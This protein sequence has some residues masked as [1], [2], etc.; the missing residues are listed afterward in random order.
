MYYS[1]TASTDLT[2]KGRWLRAFSIAETA[3]SPAIVNLRD[4]SVSGP[5]VVQLR[6]PTLAGGSDRTVSYGQPGLNFPAG[7]Y[8]EKASGTVQAAVD[9]W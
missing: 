9:L 8:V 2:T 4:G 7:C 6:F 1:V 3:G 5:I